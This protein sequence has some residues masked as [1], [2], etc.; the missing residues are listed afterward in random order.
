MALERVINHADAE[1]IAK[2]FEDSAGVTPIANTGEIDKLV[3]H[4]DGV[5]LRNAVTS[6]MGKKIDVDNLAPTE[7]SPAT[8]SHNIGDLII[9]NGELYE[10]SDEIAIGDSLAENTNITKTTI[11]DLLKTSGGHT[12]QGEDGVAVSPA[13]VLQFLQAKAETENG[14]TIITPDLITVSDVEIEEGDPIPK[15]FY[16]YVTELPYEP[17][18]WEDGSDAEIVEALQRHYQGVVDLREYWNVGDT[19]EVELSAMEATGVGEPH[20]IQ[21]VELV[22]MAKDTGIEAVTNPL[23]NYPLST[24]IGEIVRPAFIVGQKDGLCADTMADPDEDGYMNSTAS[25]TGGWASCARRTWCNSVYKAAVPETLRG[26]IKQVKVTTANDASNLDLTD[27]YVF[28]P[29]QKEVMGVQGKSAELEANALSIYP[30]Y[31]TDEN[32]WSRY[33]M[34]LTSNSSWWN[35]SPAFNTTSPSKGFCSVTYASASGSSANTHYANTV[36][37]IKPHFCI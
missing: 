6:A 24:A 9:Y 14:K 34:S 35:R 27:D 1:L 33:R 2:A 25:N 22:I 3:S 30:Y 21:T 23:Y 31:E 16:A 19:R 18:T 20:E 32:R 28:L 12:I 36:I 15:L 7:S 11:E 10:V 5:R 8:A 37:M 17:P 13:S 4:A 26:I 29:A